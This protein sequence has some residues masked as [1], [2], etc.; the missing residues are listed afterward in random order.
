MSRI[1]LPTWYPRSDS[2]EEARQALRRNMRQRA[3][4]VHAGAGLFD[5]GFAE[6]G[7]ENL[8]RKA[9]P[10]PRPR[11]PSGRWRWNRPLRPRRT[12]AP[13]SG[14]DPRAPDSSPAPGT[15][16]LFS[17]SKTA[18]SRKNAVTVMK[19][20]SHNALASSRFCSRSPAV[21]FQRFESAESHAPLDASRQSAVLVVREV[22]ASGA[23]HQ[24]EYLGQ[25]RVLRRIN[26]H[27]KIPAGLSRRA[28]WP[29]VAARFRP[30][31][32]H[33]PPHRRRWRFSA[34]RR[35]SRFAHPERR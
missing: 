19:Q 21:V 15:P 32:E 8:D 17:S 6:I 1:S 31:A 7:G 14:W 24:P 22:H 35:T 10:S 26:G 34:C 16:A 20:F 30:A 3:A 12:R 33:N 25:F 28:Q 27:P 13:R 4:R 9:R 29:P 2:R 18:G 23:P 11:I 5:G